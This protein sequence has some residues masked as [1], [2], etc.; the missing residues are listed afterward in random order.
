[1]TNRA[2]LVGNSEYT[3]LATLSCCH[4]DLVAMKEL[5]Q[6][7]GKYSEIEV[8]E[9]TDADQL[10]SK[11][12]A[13]IIENQTTEELFFYFTGHG[14]Q[15]EGEYYFCAT[16]F[17]TERPN[18]TGLSTND[19]HS[20]LK[21]TKAN[22]VVIVIDACNSGT[23]LIKTDSEIQFQPQQKQGFKNF[24]QISS[25][26]QTQISLAGDS[27]SIFT[28]QFRAAALRKKEGIVYYTDIINTLKDENIQNNEQTPFFITQGT[29]R[30]KF[31]NDA[32]CLDV[33]RDKLI[34][35]TEL[36][37]LPES[38]D[39]QAMVTQ[40]SLQTLLEEA[41]IN[42]A[43]PEK[44]TSFVDTLFNNLIERVTNDEISK[45]YDLKNHRKS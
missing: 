35:D 42:I 2:I 12:H 4:D 24:L 21:L 17:I 44:I 15:Q 18:E 7:T 31:V 29:G 40:P 33:L 34:E 9:D 5:L 23:L 28:E 1:M 10:T 30:E 22:L 37:S 38:S 11:L 20:L 27:I 39:I 19:L 32:K 16:N 41:E 8:I 43:T 36:I 26:L 13:V 6:A 3:N 14:C 25:C 45:F